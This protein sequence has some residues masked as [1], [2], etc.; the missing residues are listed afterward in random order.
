MLTTAMPLFQAVTGVQV[1]VAT[2]LCG[3]LQAVLGGQPLLIVGVAEPIVLLYKVHRA[4]SF[5]VLRSPNNEV[6]SPWSA[7]HVARR[8]FHSQC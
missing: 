6:A 4:W 7:L 5:T 8:C 3:T 2:A 1:L